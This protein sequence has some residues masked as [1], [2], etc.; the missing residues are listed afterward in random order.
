MAKGDADAVSTETV[1]EYVNDLRTVLESGEPSE[2]RAFL[3]SFVRRIE[4]FGTHVTVNY[5]L[6]LPSQDVIL[7][8]RTVLDSVQHGGPCRIRT[9]DARIKSSA[10]LVL[11]STMACLH[12]PFRS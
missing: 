3:R 8:P 5:T 12:L 7:E 2:Q 4:L 6:P 1:L 9:C 10:P 11:S